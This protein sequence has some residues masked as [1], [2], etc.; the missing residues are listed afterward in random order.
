VLA[1]DR[2]AAALRLARTN[3]ARLGLANCLVCRGDWLGAIR[4]GALDLI[5]ANPPYVRDGDP[6]LGEGDLRFEPRPA[7]AAGADGLDAIR[8][9]ALEARRCLAPGAPLAL[10]HGFDQGE[11]VRRLLGSLGL[12][13]AQTR[14]DLAGLERVSLAWA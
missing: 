13:R 14:R 3:F 2:S 6:H 8:A 11:S 9:I 10:E 4:S 5:L 12:R 1:V 7:L